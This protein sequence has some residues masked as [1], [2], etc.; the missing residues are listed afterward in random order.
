VYNI[1]LRIKRLK[2]MPPAAAAITV[3]ATLDLLDGQFADF[4]K[5][6][7]EGRYAL[8][9]GSGISLHRVPGL[10]GVVE[11]VIEFIRARINH[12][13]SGCKFA[14][15]FQDVLLL[16]NASPNERAATDST[17][18]VSE[19]PFR[20]AIVGRLVNNYARL[21]GIMIADEEFDFLVWDA[22]DVRNTYGNSALQPD[23]EHLCIAALSLEGA[24]SEMASANWDGLIE[25]ATAEMTNGNEALQPTV[26]A[27]PADLQLQ[28]NRVRLIK[29]HGCAL[30]ATQDPVSFRP[31]L[32]AR[33]DQVNGW[34]GKAKNA[35]LVTALCGLLNA[36]PTLMLGLS[37]QDG[38]IQH[39]F[40]QAA[41][42]LAWEIGTP[43]PSYV[44]S[45]NELGFDQQSLL[46]NVY[47]AQLTPANTV[48]V[49]NAARVQAYAKPL[50][51]ALLLDVLCR[52]LQALIAM[53]AGPLT[54]AER[55]PLK[56]GVKALRDGIATAAEPN[57]DFVN[58][59]LNRIGRATKL[60]RVGEI[61]D[62]AVRYQAI[63]AD[64]VSSLQANP[65]L[66]ASGLQEAA[67]ALGL[68]GVGLQRGDW[69]VDAEGL[70]ED[71]GLLAVTS[72]IP[73]TSRTKVFVTANPY[74]ATKLRAAAHVVDAQAPILIHSKE[75]M[76]PM[77]RSP[78]VPVG[79]TL[80]L[81]AREVSISALISSAASFDDLY[82]KFRRDLAL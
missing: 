79:R 3:R 56:A 65:D 80:V 16:A 60:L 37:A 73:G 40:Q 51:T 66:A 17:Q 63:S 22:V 53:A 36:K 7:S 42:D 24:V 27:R 38:N 76:M 72:C 54:E 67:I 59:L 49:F 82:D 50:L 15:A 34:C 75:L 23:V 45:E 10:W 55:Q 25:R 44:F 21:L 26:V 41:N 52:K 35:P 58:A 62:P 4:A 57:V 1:Q 19:W 74:S 28:R 70:A 32:V 48:A 43:P 81:A 6:I 8:W 11:K 30:K 20:E 29:F 71:S 77:A 69:M 68:I 64:P 12:A 31:W 33:A 39:I 78:R 14:K 5:G 61:E 47:S 13:D 9:L 46:R 2:M 18:L